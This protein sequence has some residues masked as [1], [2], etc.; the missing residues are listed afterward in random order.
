MVD[1][2]TSNIGAG[3]D[4]KRQLLIQRM[5]TKSDVMFFFFC[6]QH[7]QWAVSLHQ[8]PIQWCTDRLNSNKPVPMLPVDVS[9]T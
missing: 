5:M 2:H 4:V 6:S 7:D 3:F 9:P 8:K 1:N